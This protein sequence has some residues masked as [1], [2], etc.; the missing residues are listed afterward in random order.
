MLEVCFEKSFGDFELNICFKAE[1][2]ALGILGSSG[3]GKSMTLKCIAG[4]FAPDK[5]KI[6]LNDTVLFSSDDK[7][8]LL[9]RKR[10]IGYVFQN[11][12][13]FPHMTVAQNIA[14]GIKYIDKQ[15]RNRKVTEMIKRMQLVGFE[16][17]YPSQLSGGQ[18]QR[19]CA[20]QNLDHRTPS[21]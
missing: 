15:I 21:F 20:R 6:I 8:N 12:A 19:R 7:I 5:G 17:H 14:Y 16:K 2:G 4:L 1:K 18:Q 11:Y 9:P 13:L 10:N 3:S